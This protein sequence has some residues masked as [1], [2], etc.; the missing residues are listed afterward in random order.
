MAAVRRESHRSDACRP[1]RQKLKV[2]R[3]DDDGSDEEMLQTQNDRLVN[4]L[5][6]T[7]LAKFNLVNKKDQIL[8]NKRLTCFDRSDRHIVHQ[9]GGDFGELEYVFVDSVNFAIQFLHLRTKLHL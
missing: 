4:R 7:S 9:P 3:G 6:I 5:N 1:E 8:F 2:Q